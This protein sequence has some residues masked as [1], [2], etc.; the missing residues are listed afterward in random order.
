MPS[1]RLFGVVVNVITEDPT[2]R[3][4]NLMAIITAS[5]SPSLVIV[6]FQTDTSGSPGVRNKLNITVIIKIKTIAFMPFTINLKGT[7]DSLII[8]A[9]NTAATTY[10]TQLFTTKREMIKQMVATSFTRGSS[11]WMT[12]SA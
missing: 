2:I 8:T 4:D 11:L 5:C 7:L 9:K 12:E 1:V 6:S 3:K 10:P